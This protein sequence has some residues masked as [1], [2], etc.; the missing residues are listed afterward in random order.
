MKLQSL[1]I[2]CG[3]AHVSQ[4]NFYNCNI[5]DPLTTATSGIHSQL[6]YLGSR[7]HDTA[8]MKTSKPAWWELAVP[9]LFHASAASLVTS[10]RRYVSGIVSLSALDGEQ[11]KDT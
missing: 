6:Q 7:L 2:I 9:Y 1:W 10:N 5:W 4:V 8:A 3:P 11:Q